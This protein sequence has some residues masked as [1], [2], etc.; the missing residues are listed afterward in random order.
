MLILKWLNVVILAYLLS[1]K[2]D[3]Q[4]STNVTFIEDQDVNDVAHPG[5][6]SRSTTDENVEGVKNIIIVNHQITI[7]E[8]EDILISVGSCHVIFSDVLGMKNVVE[9]FIPEFLNFGNKNCHV[10][11]AQ[12]L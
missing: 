4:N 7:R 8:V 10:S 6:R 5:H 12:E 3:L 2:N 11:I 9:K 1:L